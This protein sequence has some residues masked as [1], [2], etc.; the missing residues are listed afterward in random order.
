[1]KENPYFNQ[2]F[3]EMLRKYRKKANVTQLKLAYLLGSSES[4]IKKM[5]KGSH[6][7]AGATIIS[8]AEILKIDPSTFLQEIMNHL[9]YLTDKNKPEK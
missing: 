3:A 4:T 8:I 5:E 7:T 6:S 9:S 1:M 2:A